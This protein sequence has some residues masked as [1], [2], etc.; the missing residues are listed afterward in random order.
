M[1]L[2]ISADIQNKKECSGIKEHIYKYDYQQMFQQ[3]IF[4][5]NID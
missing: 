4:W 2:H 1:R 3:G 5:Y